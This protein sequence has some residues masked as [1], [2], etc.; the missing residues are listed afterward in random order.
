[1]ETHIGLRVQQRIKV[2]VWLVAHNKVLTNYNRWKRRMTQ[3]AGC[4][5]C[6]C[7]KEDTLHM[8]RDCVASR[9]VW[10][11]MLLRYPQSRFFTHT[12]V[13]QWLYEGLRGHKAEK[14]KFG[15]KEIMAT[16]MWWLWKCRNDEVFDKVTRTLNERICFI[17]MRIEE[18]AAIWGRRDALQVG[19]IT[20]SVA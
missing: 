18:S 12:S 10:E 7:E 19:Y 8:V 15:W 17:Q 9:E 1:M 14:G 5:R 6:T 3:L 16:V 13:Q 2:F 11:V 20:P 4:A